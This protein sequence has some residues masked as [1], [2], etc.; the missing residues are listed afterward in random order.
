ML[1]KSAVIMYCGHCPIKRGKEEEDVKVTFVIHLQMLCVI[2]DLTA[3]SIVT[4]NKCTCF[5]N[6]TAY[7]I[8]SHQSLQ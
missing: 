5:L 1:K 2:Y 8:E 6:Y 3:L 4:D 7:Q